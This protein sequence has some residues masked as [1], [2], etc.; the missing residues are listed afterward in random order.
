M[1]G[2]PQ[3]LASCDALSTITERV[4]CCSVGVISPQ[5]AVS[6]ERD[7]MENYHLHTQA[8]DN[9]LTSISAERGRGAH[10]H[11]LGINEILEGGREAQVLITY[12]K[13]S[14]VGEEELSD[15]L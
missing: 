12:A 10:R 7:V 6:T 4:R 11:K 1:S 14:F 13:V 8:L 9:S 5:D 15:P 3:S 2:A